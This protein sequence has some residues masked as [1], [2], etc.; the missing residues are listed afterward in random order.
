MTPAIRDLDPLPPEQARIDG[1]N[2]RS[3]QRQRDGERRQQEIERHV[4]WIGEDVPGRVERRER[5]RDRC[6]EAGQQQHA[7]D[8]RKRVRCDRRPRGSSTERS[9][10][11]NDQRYSCSDAEDEKPAGRSAAGE[12]GE[13]STHSASLGATRP[14]R[15]ARMG[16]IAADL[17]A[18]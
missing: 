16:G 1:P 15:N 12:R 4:A 14:R 5:A 10:R 18:G 6:P 11:G 8:R 3:E 13:Q 9:D 7:Q 2:A 17:S